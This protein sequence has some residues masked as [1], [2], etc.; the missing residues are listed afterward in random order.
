[1]Q[2][3]FRN[4]FNM[5]A[6]KFVCGDQA[7]DCSSAFFNWAGALPRSFDQLVMD[8]PSNVWDDLSNLGYNRDK[9]KAEMDTTLKQL[10]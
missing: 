8:G 9:I 7:A 4:R 2:I 10:R 6:V 3:N 1:M 5:R